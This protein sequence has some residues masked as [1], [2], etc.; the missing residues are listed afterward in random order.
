[1][2]GYPIGPQQTLEI[3]NTII[4]NQN[5]HNINVTIDETP[6]SLTVEGLQLYIN[7]LH[8]VPH[9][10]FSNSKGMFHC[11]D[12]KTGATYL[13]KVIDRGFKYKLDSILKD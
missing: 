13:I 4:I 5:S 6:A 1:M 7:S 8:L 9:N 12:S 3:K 2:A 11:T 10:P